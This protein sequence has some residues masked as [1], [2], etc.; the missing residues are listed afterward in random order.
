LVNGS[1]TAT[2]GSDFDLVGDSIV[3]LPGE[4][5]TQDITVRIYN[6]DF[7]ESSETIVLD[8]AVHSPTQTNVVMGTQNQATITLLQSDFPPN[9]TTSFSQIGSATVTHTSQPFAGSNHDS[10]TQ[11]KVTSFCRSS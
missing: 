10:R 7:T 8:L 11:I 3:F 4:S 6:D 9:T 1:T 5:L 2:E